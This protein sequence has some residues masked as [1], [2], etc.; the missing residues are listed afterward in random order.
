MTV[1]F[2]DFREQVGHYIQLSRQRSLYDQLLGTVEQFIEIDMF[3]D[4]AVIQA[5]HTLGDTG[6]QNSPLSR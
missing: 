2:G 6:R 4:E 5:F 1:G 3:S